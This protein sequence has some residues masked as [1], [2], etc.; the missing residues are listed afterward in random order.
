VVCVASL[1]ADSLMLFC[2]V[3]EAIPTPWAGSSRADVHCEIQFA[4]HAVLEAARST[5]ASAALRT[6]KLRCSVRTLQSASKMPAFVI[7]LDK[8]TDR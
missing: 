2:S 1:Y 8:R 4:T 3:L 7:N 5:Q 6:L